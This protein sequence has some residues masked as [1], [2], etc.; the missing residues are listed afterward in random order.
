M[1]FYNERVLPHLIALAMRKR[2]LA[3]YRRRVVPAASGRVLEVGIGSG[4]NLPFYGPGV[5]Q[6][7]GL[8]PSPELLA[9][10]NRQSEA[11]QGKVSL[12]EGVAEAIPLDD[13]NIDTAVMT[14]TLCS[15]AH[16]SQ[17]LREVRRV[18]KPGGDLL[19]VEHGAAPDMGVLKWQDRL[20]PIWKQV[21]GGCHLNRDTAL[22]LRSAGF[23]LCDLRR[24]YMGGPRPFTFMSEGRAQS[25]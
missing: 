19:F 9:M 22:L 24:G 1:S 2:D 13:G 11:M 20:T 17:A 6:I 12:I 25:I 14:W 7:F 4:L 18:L 8:D 16:P 5:E 15:V 10:A 23:H 3:E 21:S